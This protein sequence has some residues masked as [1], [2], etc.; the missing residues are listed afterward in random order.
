MMKMNKGISSQM[1]RAAM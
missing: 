1:K